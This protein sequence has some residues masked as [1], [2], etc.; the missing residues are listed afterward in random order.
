MD[1]GQRT[2]G[3]MDVG[4]GC[5]S[6]GR[7]DSWLPTESQAGLQRLYAPLSLSTFLVLLAEL[8]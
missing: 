6:R 8:E 1:G 4:D 3:R 2:D 5:H 7:G